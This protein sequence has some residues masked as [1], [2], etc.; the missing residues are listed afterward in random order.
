MQYFF[1]YITQR[2]VEPTLDCSEQS[3]FV[4]SLT[5]HFFKHYRQSTH[6]I[7]QLKV[8]RAITVY[9]DVQARILGR[10]P[11]LFCRLSRPTRMRPASGSERRRS[12]PAG[13]E[14]KLRPAY[15]RHQLR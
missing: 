1:T 13:H 12:K 14:R 15:G 9:V 3:S 6:H 7:C 2:D 5:R 4:W 10:V 11:R 8:L